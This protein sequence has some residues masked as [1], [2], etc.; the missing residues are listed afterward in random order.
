MK[1]SLITTESSCHVCRV[2]VARQKH[3]DPNISQMYIDSYFPVNDCLNPDAYGVVVC[4]WHPKPDFDNIPMG[5]LYYDFTTYTYNN[6]S[7]GHML[8]ENR[9]PKTIGKKWA[10]IAAEY[11]ADN[12]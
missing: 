4:L 2:K 1:P 5:E 10:N 7:D 12:R 9:K 8:F 6:Q 3:W 11:Y